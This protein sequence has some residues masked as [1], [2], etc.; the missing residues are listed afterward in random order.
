MS[1]RE[2]IAKAIVDRWVEKIDDATVRVGPPVMADAILSALREAGMA[3]VSADAV[4]ALG[5]RLAAFPVCDSGGCNTLKVC[6]C[7][8]IEDAYDE[9]RSMIAADPG[10]AIEHDRSHD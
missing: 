6:A 2:I 4:R 9:L 5:D 1:A 3:V 10:R 8:T 7:A